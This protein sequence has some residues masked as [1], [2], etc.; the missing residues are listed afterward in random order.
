MSNISQGRLSSHSPYC[1]QFSLRIDCFID[2]HFQNWNNTWYM[3]TLFPKIIVTC[4][5]SRL[6][7]SWKERQH[8]LLPPLHVEAFTCLRFMLKLSRENKSAADIVRS[9]DSPCTQAD[10]PAKKALALLAALFINYFHQLA[11]IYFLKKIRSPLL[12][13]T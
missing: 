10:F 9:N 6:L 13:E 8:H 7:G 11:F 3:L 2:R 12:G 1:G 5:S 4:L